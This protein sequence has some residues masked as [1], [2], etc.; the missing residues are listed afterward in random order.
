MEMEV[1]METETERDRDIDREIGMCCP[2][3]FAG[4]KNCACTC[5]SITIAT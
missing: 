4:F 5:T 3:I 2:F 1:E